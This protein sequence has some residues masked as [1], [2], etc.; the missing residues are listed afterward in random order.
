MAKAALELNKLNSTNVEEEKK[1]EDGED[2]LNSK[3][4][5]LQDAKTKKKGKNKGKKD[6]DD[7]PEDN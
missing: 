6:D 3:F 1:E 5:S 4:K 2:K 7:F